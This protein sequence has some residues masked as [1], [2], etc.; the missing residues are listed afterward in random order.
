MAGKF[1][2]EEILVGRQQP[3]LCAPVMVLELFVTCD[4]LE[5]VLGCRARHSLQVFSLRHW[6][7]WRGVGEQGDGPV[8]Q[9]ILV[10]R[11]GRVTVSS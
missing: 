5:N 4:G 11:G 3:P 9:P 2:K 7:G 6:S 1:S 8:K 10:G